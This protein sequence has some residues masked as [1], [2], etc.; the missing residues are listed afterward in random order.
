MIEVRL[1]SSSSWS[2]WNLSQ[3]IHLSCV[4][5]TVSTSVLQEW[6]CWE[7]VRP[8]F[9]YQGI[10]WLEE[11]LILLIYQDMVDQSPHFPKCITIKLVKTVWLKILGKLFWIS[12]KTVL[13]GNEQSTWLY[14]QGH[15]TLFLL[16]VCLFICTFN[17]QWW[18]IWET[19]GIDPSCPDIFG[20]SRN[21]PDLPRGLTDSGN[22]AISD[23]T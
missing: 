3:W 5:D 7:P 16:C 10:F 8:P 13:N 20:K 23:D 11:H 18:K 21:K 15:L 14:F 6:T 17:S 12:N 9:R 2:P 19:V 22:Y 4:K 1:H